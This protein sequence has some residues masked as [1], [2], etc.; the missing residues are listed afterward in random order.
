V[1]AEREAA[2]GEVLPRQLGEDQQSRHCGDPAP[3]GRDEHA[4][5][6]DEERLGDHERDI[7]ARVEL[8]RPREPDRELAYAG[9]Q[10]GE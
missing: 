4:G 3:T 2:E 10:A 5:E 7:A 6:G 1:P 8:H 9:E